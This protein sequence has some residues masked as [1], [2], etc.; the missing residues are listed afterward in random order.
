MR[1][2]RKL[3]ACVISDTHLGTYG[4]HAKELKTYLSS[5]NPEVLVLNGDI[6]DIWS[7]RKSYF[8][9]D[10]M[11]VIRT[12]IKMAERGTK[13][14]YVTGNHDE[15]LREYSDMSLGNIHLVDKYILELDGNVHWIFH[16]DIFDHTTK[17]YAK[18][19]AKLGG[20][21]YDL[22]ILVNRFINKML[23]GVGQ[24]KMSLSKKVK[25]S[26]KHA[27]K[28]IGNFETT[29]AELAIQQG[30][31]Y[32]IC[33]H[34]HQPKI[35]QIHT[36]EG[37]TT[38]LNSGDWIENLTA[39]EYHQG[40]W[41]LYHYEEEMSKFEPTVKDLVAQMPLEQVLAMRPDL[42]GRQSN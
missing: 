1:T 11:K 36:S 17:G 33:G 31:D 4:C 40:H 28:W 32:V 26:V 5:I 16:G 25:A 41:N 14:V 8:P 15:A 20:K 2:R 30:F 10:H 42:L 34:I 7:F 24:E 13:I 6:I 29:A 12:L 27:V 18:I 19:L 35:K 21:G 39:L 22:L 37:S 3:A 9:A 23:A 38:Y